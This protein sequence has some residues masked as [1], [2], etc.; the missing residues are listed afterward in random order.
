MRISVNVV[1]I[2]VA[3]PGKAEELRTLLTG[4][5]S[6]SRAE[7]GNLQNIT[8]QQSTILPSALPWCLIRSMPCEGSFV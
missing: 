1:A 7:P 6:P 2:L 4:M 8:F 5:V 3:W